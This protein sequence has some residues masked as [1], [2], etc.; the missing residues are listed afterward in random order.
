M[1]LVV[2][3]FAYFSLVEIAGL[4]IEGVDSS[5]DLYFIKELSG[6][7]FSFLIS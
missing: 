7:L 6:L 3:S 2:N 1:S 5:F 4:I